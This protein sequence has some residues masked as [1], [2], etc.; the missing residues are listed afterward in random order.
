MKRKTGFLLVLLCSA[1]WLFATGEAEDAETEGT[2]IHTLS[3]T[4]SHLYQ[5]P[6]KEQAFKDLFKQ[7]TGIN[8][9]IVHLPTGD[10][11]KMIMPLYAA[12]TNADISQMPNQIT[13]FIIQE[14]LAPLDS[15]IESSPEWMRLKKDAPGMFTAGAFMGQTYALSSKAGQS[16]VCWMRKDWLDK[17]GLDVPASMDEMISTLEAF[18]TL[19]DVRGK[20]V[21]PLVMTSHIWNHD[22]F[23]AYYGVFNQV[24]KVGDSP[25]TE[26]YL[27]PEF[28]EYIDMMKQL[29]KKGLLDKETPT[30]RNGAVRQKFREGYAGALVMWENSYAGLISGLR[31]NGFEDAEIIAVPP[32]EGPNGVFGLSSSVAPTRIAISAS[33]KNPEMAFNSFLSWMF[34]EENGIMSTTIGIPG[35]DFEVI[36]GMHSAIEDRPMGPIIQAFPAVDPNFE[37]PF[38]FDEIGQD[39]YNII[40]TIKQWTK[41]NFNKVFK[42]YPPNESSEYWSID[43][44]L[45]DK[46]RSLFGRY[47][48]G[49]INYSEFTKEY[50]QYIKE[51]NLP[52]LLEEINS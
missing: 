11:T 5:K 39:R 7:D 30:N 37:Y 3:F 1:V 32:F 40:K 2:E 47:I 38:E 10:W 36:N 50:E 15:Y 24:V 19:E 27:T 8:L 31:S 45:Y 6:E 52:A 26:Y 20:S 23:A 44:S 35:Y 48:M 49:D 4:T 21:I 14:F 17:L 16:M 33:A 41:K 28:K 12:G 51:I 9:E 42:Q 13:P 43:A 34:L 25:Y 46:K 29:Y 18:K 22:A